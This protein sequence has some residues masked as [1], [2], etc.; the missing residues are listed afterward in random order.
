MA[1]SLGSSCRTGLE[2]CPQD[3]TGGVLLEC[4]PPTP[5]R[6]ARGSLSASGLP[7]PAHRLRVLV[8]VTKNQIK[9]SLN[10]NF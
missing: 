5:Y 4:D 3:V 6:C 1:Q 10:P 8:L 9:L 7:R 2:A